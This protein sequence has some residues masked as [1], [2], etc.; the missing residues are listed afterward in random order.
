MRYR[1]GVEVR[2]GDRV[3]VFDADVGTVVFSIDTDEY[4]A[5]FPK[6][7]WNYLKKG[8]MIQIEAPS[9]I[10]MQPMRVA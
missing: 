4:A 6:A 3:K 8:V 10:S 1:D 9:F 7:V 5:E 2:L